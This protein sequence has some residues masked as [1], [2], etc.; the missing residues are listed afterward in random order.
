M[1]D[2]IAIP[3]ERLKVLRKNKKL[4]EQLEKFTD[5]K[6]EINE[7][8]SIECEDPLRLMRIKEVLK[9]FGRGFDFNVALNLLDEDYYLEIIDIK[10]YSK[11]SRNRMITLRG[12][13]IGTEG[14]TKKLIEK[15]AD[16]KI[17]IYGKTISII[18]KWDKIMIAKKAI[19]MLL[20]GSLHSS[21]YRFL[22]KQRA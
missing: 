9:A 15:Y 3:E 22:E 7:E 8:I 11:K 17:S 10:D 19:E 18:G 1:I 4:I 16:V 12:R 5:S 13:V 21:V 6:I 20:S 2:Y 14:K